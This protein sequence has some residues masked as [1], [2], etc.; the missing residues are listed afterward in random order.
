MHFFPRRWHRA[1]L[2]CSMLL[3]LAGCGDRRP[4]APPLT[5]E[6]IDDP[7]ERVTALDVVEDL[8]ETVTKR[9][10]ELCWHASQRDEAAMGRYLADDFRGR[11]LAHAAA[12][13]A[14]EA[15]AGI[16]ATTFDA[17]AAPVV[18]RQAFVTS[19]RAFLA[20]FDHV[21][22]LLPQTTGAEFALGVPGWAALDVNLHAYGSDARGGRIERHATTR[23]RC[24]ERV[25]VWL[26]TRCEVL[27]MSEQ[28]RM[29]PLFTDVT[30]SAGIA[31]DGPRFGTEGNDSFFWNGAA[32]AD[33]DGDGRF[34]LFVPSQQQNHLY[35]NLGNGA[36]EDI[37]AR[38][39]VDQ[40]AHG[41][42][43]LFFDADA[44]GDDDLLVGRVG[45]R[46][47]GEVVGGPCLFFEHL[48][49]GTF[50][51]CGEERGFTDLLCAYSLAAAD[52]DNDG[53]LDVYVCG[54]NAEGVIAADSWLD[55]RNGTP[56]ALYHN[57]GNG[58]FRDIAA[59]A[60]VDDPT[61]SYAAAFADFDQDG[62]QDLYVAN[63]YGPNRLFANNADLTFTDRAQELGVLDVGNGM[64]VNWG[65]IDQDGD[66]DLYVSNM[67]STAGNRI[68][69]RIVDP[70]R[71]GALAATLLKLAAGNTIFAYDDHRF[72]PLEPSAG[73]IDAHWA[74]S[75]QFTDIDLDGDEDLMCVNG[76]ISGDAEVKFQ[77]SC[78]TYWR[79]V[80]ASSLPGHSEYVAE[81]PNSPAYLDHHGSLM[82]EDGLSF[83]GY[84]RDRVWL[85]DGER[86]LDVSGVSGAD[87]PNDGRALVL[88]DADD[89]G[90]EDVFVHNTQKSRHHL[91]RNDAPDRS[92]NRSIKLRL[93]ATAGH[94]QAAGAV[95]RA[96]LGDHTLAKVLAF[97]SGF[98]SQNAPELVFGTGTADSAEITVQWPG[99]A[100]E[101][102]GRL[103]S[104]GTYLLDEGTGAAQ[105]IERRPLRFLDP[106]HPGVRVRAGERLP[107]LPLLDV[108][109][110]AAPITPGTSGRPMILGLWAM[111]CQPC[112]GELEA[113]S[114]I[115]AAGTHDV[116]VINIDAQ[117]DWPRTA[118]LLD[119]MKVTA[120]RAWLG[121]DAAAILADPTRLALPAAIVLD[122]DGRV[123]QVVQGSIETAI[124]S[125]N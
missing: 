49:D 59:A 67:S 12:A 115:A 5:L 109:G 83:S 8:S 38:V 14:A 123:E 37:A 82:F 121:A 95:V 69:R 7:T 105:T 3:S 87:D 4:V 30:A 119:R 57:Q 104:G 48:Q 117:A 84:E 118:T 100:A 122:R 45:F 35:R 13:P 22:S 31:L 34:D 15:A 91:Y 23:L 103:T 85:R 78:S 80:V 68:L 64:G 98:L 10:I 24:E 53:Q 86:Y 19:L 55:A 54:Y 2:P 106:A 114:R 17:T 50:R 102:F 92:G 74:W 79:H 71:D 6:P 90:D 96:R 11:D 112:M 61:W 29:T 32:C 107:S 110:A 28:R 111:W 25:G 26:I 44:D 51:A 16:L 63:D 76:F 27:A 113:L 52:V 1:L 72:T 65:D 66:L 18:D 88:L 116:L 33:V 77:D 81:T 58:R 40:P 41:T 94:P 60:G 46:D 125:G 62:D 70:A 39:G 93:R 21:D 47:K 101:A 43:A 36:F 75:A 97:G 89:D 120:Q 73:G 42:G 56:N 99:R 9:L 108:A 124:P 20:P